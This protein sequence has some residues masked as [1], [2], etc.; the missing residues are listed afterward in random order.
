VDS[1]GI[2]AKSGNSEPEGDEAEAI[3]RADAKRLGLSYHDYCKQFGIT[4]PSQR[5]QYRR[6]E[7]PLKE[8]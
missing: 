8:E 7:V 6:R 2:R 4:G 5:R 3:F 1:K